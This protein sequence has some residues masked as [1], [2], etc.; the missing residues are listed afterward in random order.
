MFLQGANHW[1]KWPE[2]M[3]TELRQMFRVNRL[4]GSYGLKSVKNI[5]R[6]DYKEFVCGAPCAVMAITMLFADT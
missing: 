6:L 4:S 3:I 2:E 1:L 5:Y